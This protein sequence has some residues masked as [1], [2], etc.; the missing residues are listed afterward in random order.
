M[1]CAARMPPGG[2]VEDARESGAVLAREGV[3]GSGVRGKRMREGEAQ[4]EMW[5]VEEGRVQG[6]WSGESA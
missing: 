3:E 2:W 6:R 5:V 1:S 4:G